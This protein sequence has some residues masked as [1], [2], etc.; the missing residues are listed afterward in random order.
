[1]GIPTTTGLNTALSG[2]EAAQAAIDTTGQNISNASTPGYT[3]QVVNTTESAEQSV[4][5]ATN[6]GT[7]LL[8]TGVDISS[9]SRIRDQFLDIQYRAQNTATNNANTTSTELQQVQ[10]AVNEPSTDGISSALSAF[11]QAWG[12]VASN[13]A[14]ASSAAALQTLVGKGQTLAQTFNSVSAQMSTVQ[15]QAA[16][17]YSTLTGA[18]GQVQQD[19]NQVATLN[20]EISAASGSGQTDNTL[21]DQR[22]NVLDDLS[23]LAQ[24]SITN[25]TDGSVT[26][27]FGGATT[28]LV[29]GTTVNWPPTLTS[30]SG[31]ELG[32]LQSLS[33]ATGPIGTM[34]TS[35]NNVAAQ[36][37]AAV[38]GLQPAAT[39]F[40][41]ATTGSEA[42]TITVTPAVVATPSTIQTSTL[43]TSDGSVA[44]SIAALQNGPADQS[45]AAF[46]AQVGD[47]VE[48]AQ[49]TQSTAQSLLTA[50]GNQRESVS[51]VSLDEEMTNLTNYQQAYE[52]S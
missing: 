20:G 41:S 51:G 40:F 18:N 22:D 1:M 23:S 16:Q 37:V 10:T 29:N 7:V 14:G 9:I 15:T 17:Q 38:N 5:G 34:L 13:P 2:L 3:R 49:S 4:P 21:L 46:V 27:N 52:A 42:S 28:P 24:V 35:L 50:I 45:Y 12:T 8:G 25:Q 44:Q 32:S 36:V 6:T 30:A 43:G 11:W 33:S 26:V 19:A 48:S 47:S 39:P 31:G